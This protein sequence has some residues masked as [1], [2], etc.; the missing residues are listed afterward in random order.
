MRKLALVVLLFSSLAFA[1][2][3]NTYYAAQLPGTTVGQKVAAAQAM[4]DSNTS[5]PCYIVIDPN[6]AVMPVG[7]MPTKCAQCVWSDYR[8]SA[9]SA[10]FGP[11]TAQSVG[12]SASG[13]FSTW[14]QPNLWLFGGMT[15]SAIESMQGWSGSGYSGTVS[16]G[17][18]IGIRVPAVGS[19]VG[20]TNGV[21]VYL[22]SLAPAN[23]G[24][25][26]PNPVGY[27]ANVS[28]GASTAIGSSIWGANLNLIDHGYAINEYGLELDCNAANAATAGACLFFGNAS[29][30]NAT[31]L[32]AINIPPP[33]GGYPWGY[34]IV[35]EDGSVT[36]TGIGL[37]A[38]TTTANSTSM[39][40][41]FNGRNS[42]NVPINFGS[43]L[44]ESLA[45]GPNSGLYLSVPLVQT[46]SLALGNSS[47]ASTPYLDF[48]S[49]GNASASHTYDARIIASGGSS[50]AGQGTLTISAAVVAL[51][52]STTFNT[53][54]NN[55][56]TALKH[57]RVTSCT[58]GAVTGDT[59]QT[60]VTW[61]TAFADANYTVTCSY[62]A[63]SNAGQ[64]YYLNGKT[65][66]GVVVTTAALGAAAASGIIDC[67]AMH[68]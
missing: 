66:S 30:A 4:C 64:L 38:Q 49:S 18:S 57:K 13:S 36:G 46:Q 34:G 5:V 15:E 58:T 31:N 7:T 68:D 8:S 9:P 25:I 22:N 27:Y 37:G 45:D 32:G 33:D 40:I 39:P 63:T 17:L 41:V 52:S 54:V 20:Q 24:G 53:S 62:E 21:G 28:A 60:T 47:G 2:R 67:I 55:N 26:G 65:A 10:Q 56:G 50:T 61:T 29:T 23:A 42:S 35:L 3:T 43:V 16:D 12:V 6:L 19:S 44:G 14:S 11:V 48:L 59:C 1:Q 51:N